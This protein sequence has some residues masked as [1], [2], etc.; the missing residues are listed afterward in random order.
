VSYDAIGTLSPGNLVK[1]RGIPCGQITKVELTDDAV[2]VTLEVLAET[3]IPKNSEFRLITAGLMGEREMCVLTG[4]SKELV[5]QGD[6]LVGHFDQGMAGFGKKVGTILADL[7]ELRDSAR[8]V[9]DSLSNG[10]A[11]EQLNRVS[12]KAKTVVR[13]T[14]VNVNSWK[15]QVDSLLDECDHSLGNA[16]VALEAIAQT[17]AAKVHDLGSLVDRTRKLLETV[18]ALK[19]QSATVLGK[20]MQDDNTAGLIV[21]QDSP[22]NKG[23]DKLLQDVDALLNDIKKS[24]LDINVDIF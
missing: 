19:E 13:K 16:Q 20:L 22:F 2:Y 24:G 9:M 6:T 3:I 7:G 1:V 18:K 10:Q 12:R 17:G 11:G 23:L 15:A 5:H 8:S 21:S 4:D 14:K